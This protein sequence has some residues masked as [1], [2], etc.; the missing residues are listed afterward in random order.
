LPVVC[1]QQAC[2]VL[3]PSC[4]VNILYA[5]NA[6]HTSCMDVLYAFNALPTP[7]V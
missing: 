4:Y 2:T 3:L 7:R 1:D 6:T 5:F